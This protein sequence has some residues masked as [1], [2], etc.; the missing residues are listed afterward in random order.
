MQSTITLILTSRVS[1]QSQEGS[2]VKLSVVNLK[3]D[4]I[5]SVLKRNSITFK[6]A[7]S[8]EIL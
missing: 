6:V 2:T 3:M 7:K 5:L 4:T 1:Q 8:K